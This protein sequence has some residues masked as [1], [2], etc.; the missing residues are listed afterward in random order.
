[1]SQPE[2]ISGRQESG[3]PESTPNTQLSRIRRKKTA[4]GAS[5]I[6]ALVLGL[7]VYFLAGGP[8]WSAGADAP[9]PTLKAAIVDQ[10]SLT[11]PSPE[12]TSSARSMLEEAGYEVYYYP[13]EQVTVDFYRS[14]PTHGFDLILLRVHS[15]YDPSVDAVGLFTGEP[16]V[17][18]KYPGQGVGFTAYYEGAPPLFGIGP[19]FIESTME[20]KF[21][22]T[23]I[24]MMGC[25][26]LTSIATAEAFVQKGAASVVSWDGQVLASHT[27]LA[28]EQ[29][30][31]Y[32]L[33]DGLSMPEAVRLTMSEVGP[34]PSFNSKLLLHQA[35]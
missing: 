34:D 7:I 32:L 33:S 2:K 24:V 20:G 16:Y 29:L 26:G 14:L 1:M 8:L 11:V 9:A 27:D 6:G 3:A 12:F 25:D 31:Q 30:L 13:G 5:V 4:A 35:Q 19:R 10:L 18:G 23:T 15:G 28:T 21:D 17:E 22:G